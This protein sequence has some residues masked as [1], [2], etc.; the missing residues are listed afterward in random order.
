MS[1][2]CQTF[3]ILSSPA[4]KNHLPAGSKASALIGAVWSDSGSFT[5]VLLLQSIQNVAEFWTGAK[6]HVV[7]IPSS[8]KAQGK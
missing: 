1:A 3:T 4:A 5:K 7:I 2:S 8:R 6:R